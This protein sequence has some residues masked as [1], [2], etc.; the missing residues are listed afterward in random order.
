[1]ADYD[2]RLSADDLKAAVRSYAADADAVDTKAA[3]SVGRDQIAQSL[4]ALRKETGGGPHTTDVAKLAFPHPDTAVLTTRWQA[5]TSTP[6]GQRGMGIVVFQNTQG[7]WSI[8]ATHS[9]ISRGA[10]PAKR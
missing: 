1:L 8:V 10:P 4:A 5:N 6:Q 9:T 3:R 7:Q 2:Q